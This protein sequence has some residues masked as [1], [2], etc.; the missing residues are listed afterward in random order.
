VHHP[1]TPG[2]ATD[3]ADRLGYRGASLHQPQDLSVEVVNLGA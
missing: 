2:G 3:L 1:W